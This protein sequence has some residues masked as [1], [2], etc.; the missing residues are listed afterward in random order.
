MEKEVC[1]Q[2]FESLRRHK[3]EELDKRTFLQR[4]RE[5]SKNDPRM[6]SFLEDGECTPYIPELIQSTV[7][8]YT[9]IP[10][11][12]RVQSVLVY[13]KN[14]TVVVVQ[15]KDR[16]YP[17]VL[18]KSSGKNDEPQFKNVYF[19]FY[20]IASDGI[21]K[22]I[23]KP[24]F[25]RKFAYDLYVKQ[26]ASHFQDEDE[27]FVSAYLS[28]DVI[29]KLPETVQELLEEF[30]DLRISPRRIEPLDLEISNETIPWIPPDHQDIEWLP[31]G[32]T[33]KECGGG[34]DCLYHALAFIFSERY[35]TH[36]TM[37]QVR[38]EFSE[39]INESNIDQLSGSLQEARTPKYRDFMETIE[40]RLGEKIKRNPD[41]INEILGDFPV[42]VE[43]ILENISKNKK[44]E[45]PF[46]TPK[47]W[48]QIRPSIINLA[49]DLYKRPG[50]IWGDHEV[51]GILSKKYKIT[52]I[53]LSD[54]TRRVYCQNLQCNPYVA[55][56]YWYDQVHYQV[57]FYKEKSIYKMQDVPEE[58]KTLI[59][60]QCP[61]HQLFG[62]CI[63]RAD[64]Y[65]IIK[66][67]Y[68]DG[69][70][71][72]IIPLFDDNDQEAARLVSEDGGTIFTYEVDRTRVGNRPESVYD[73]PAAYPATFRKILIKQGDAIFDLMF[74]RGYELEEEIA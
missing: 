70:N 54:E 65:T 14:R 56:L 28:G 19:P 37:Q 3:E 18:Y 72:V 7:I 63:P 6:F 36:I 21:I 57:A 52:F 45:S 49:K 42:N 68:T 34:G 27:M 61:H 8:M 69:D 73:R 15:L 33:K 16:K 50:I 20:W 9:H 12:P 4:V 64:Q 32:W 51:L 5:A 48:N 22:A 43:A 41:K 38:D 11:P 40:I 13:D 1:Q 62:Y 66:H 74:P 46:W 2:L 23:P 29:Q 53:L 71:R 26:F 47:I 31:I 30:S 55:F 17:I 44:L 24:A 25:R 67:F 35:N 59:Q 58:V 10:R 39:L 60:T